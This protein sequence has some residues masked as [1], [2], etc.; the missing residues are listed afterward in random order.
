MIQ[1]HTNNG[2]DQQEHKQDEMQQNELPE[3]QE[4][5]QPVTTQVRTQNYD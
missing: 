3:A 2:P 4:H 1:K 5:L